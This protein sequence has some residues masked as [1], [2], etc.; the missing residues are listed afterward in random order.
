MIQSFW[1]QIWRGKSIVRA[2]MNVA[3][4]R[5]PLFDG[6][7]LDIGGTQVPRPSYRDYIR[8]GST[9][10][11]KTL[12]I[13]AASEPDFVA[14]AAHIPCP[15]GSF[16]HA[17]CLNVLEHVPDPVAILKEALRVVK[18]GGRLVVFTPFLVA[19]HGHP[20]DYAR[21]TE[22]ALR[23]MAAD[24]G[25]CIQEVR[26][27]EVGPWTTASTFIQSSVPRIIYF[28][29]AYCATGL[30][31]VWR[32]FHRSAVTIR[33][34]GYLLCCQKDVGQKSTQQ[35]PAVSADPLEAAIDRY[36]TLQS[37]RPGYAV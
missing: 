9:A 2:S 15:D 34:L 19:V 25:W 10:E 30:D 32:W 27:I 5:L 4:A 1:R 35:D 29:L 7:L 36:C 28:L 14:D 26:A 6:A 23:R 31:D 17:W 33:P 18:P 20:D 22:T 12:N 3:L 8:I 13:D 11:V 37:H 24:A 21:Y 16:D